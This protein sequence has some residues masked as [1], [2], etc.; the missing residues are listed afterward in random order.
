AHISI[1][2]GRGIGDVRVESAHGSFDRW[3]IDS[4]H[5]RG[6]PPVHANRVGGAP[7]S[8]N[9]SALWSRGFYFVR[10]RHGFSHGGAVMVVVGRPRRWARMP[11]CWVSG[12]SYL[13]RPAPRH[14]AAAG[15][16][17]F[18]INLL[19]SAPPPS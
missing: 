6:Q 9:G 7:G 15:F 13:A 17:I 11:V 3:S 19:P 18:L 2:D 4:H 10:W 16:G 5:R 1:Y 8:G 12:W 14:C